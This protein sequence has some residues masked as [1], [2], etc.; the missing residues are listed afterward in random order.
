MAFLARAGYDVFSVDMTGYGGSARPAPMNDPCNLAK[1]RQAGF[2]AAPCAAK[3]PAYS[4]VHGVGL[5]RSRRRRRLHTR[6]AARRSCGPGGVVTR[7]SARRRVR[8]SASRQ[9]PPAG[10]ACA[11]LRSDN[12]R[13]CIREDRRRRCSDEHAI[14]AGFRRELGSP[15][16]VR[17][18]IRPGRGRIP[19][20]RRCSHRIQWALRGAPA[21]GA[22]R[23]PRARGRRRW[24]RS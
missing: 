23:K 11:C 3:L 7:R 4:D 21:S 19:C 16:R 22:R 1:D 6:P 10:R 20:G 8:R 9:G 15:G 24:P 17:G 2:V 18:S 13:R 12:D 14:T 5:E